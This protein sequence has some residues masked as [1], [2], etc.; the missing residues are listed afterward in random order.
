MSIGCLR[1][2]LNQAQ[3]DAGVC[4]GS[5]PE[6]IANSGMEDYILGCFL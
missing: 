2:D 5:A 3:G 4:L 6:F 1:E